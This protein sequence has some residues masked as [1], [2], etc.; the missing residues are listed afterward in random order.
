M[1]ALHRVGPVQRLVEHEHARIGD[2]R[3]GDLGALAHALAEPVDATIGDVEQIDGVE[4]AIDRVVVGDAVEVGDVA[5]ELASG[6][7]GGHR[8]VLGHQGERPLHLT[9]G[10]RVAPSTRIWP[11]S[12]RAGRSSPA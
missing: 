8:F 1:H 6:E 4:R 7:P 12:G 10:P 9:I 5:N 3:R 2:E 11:G